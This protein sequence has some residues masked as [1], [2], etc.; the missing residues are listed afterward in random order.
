[1]LLKEADAS[2]VIIKR[3]L[4]AIASSRS[5]HNLTSVYFYI[6]ATRLTVKLREMA[7]K[8]KEQQDMSPFVYTMQ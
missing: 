4:D 1:M 8:P 2:A 7:D 5:D 6:Y 3:I